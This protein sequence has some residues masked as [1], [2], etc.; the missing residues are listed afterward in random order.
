MPTYYP[1]QSVTV[2]YAQSRYLG[3]GELVWQG[4]N[5]CQVF[6]YLIGV[7]TANHAPCKILP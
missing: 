7:H 4:I 1:V 3:I 2:M 6:L 5:L